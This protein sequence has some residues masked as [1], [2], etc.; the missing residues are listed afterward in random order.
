MNDP[1]EMEGNTLFVELFS[2]KLIINYG[3]EVWHTVCNF[4]RQLGIWK[5]Q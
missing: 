4:T 2:Q 5:F 3:M 1:E